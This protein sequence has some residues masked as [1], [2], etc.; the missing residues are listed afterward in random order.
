MCCCRL[1]R[2]SRCPSSAPV[3][4]QGAPGGSEQHGTPMQRPAHWAPSGPS[5]CAAI[6]SLPPPKSPMSP[7]YKVGAKERLSEGRCSRGSSSR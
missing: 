3:P 4:P 1:G 5:H 7:P 6:S 2:Q